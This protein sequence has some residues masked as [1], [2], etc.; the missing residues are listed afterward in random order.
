MPDQELTE[1][2]PEIA[3][4]IASEK[5]RQ[6]S[7]LELIAS[8]NF[9]SKAVMQAMGS[10]L[11]NKY[12]EGYPGKRYYGGNE[13]IDQMEILCQ[14]RTLAAFG[15]SG[16]EWGVNVQPLSGSPANFAVYT[17]LMQPGDKIM[18]LSLAHGGHLTHGHQTE[19]KKI[20]ASSI[21][22]ESQPYYVR[23]EDGLIDYEALAKQAA[24]F[25]PKMI[26]VG[27]SA[28]P[29]DYDYAKFREI[30]N[31][32]GAFLM[33]DIAHTSGLIASKLLNQPFEYC[34]VVTTTTHK[35]LRGPRSGL[36]MA[37]KQYIDAINFAVF[38]SLQ[39]GPHNVSIAA[40]AVQLK[41]VA[42]PEFK[43]YSQ[44]VI[45]NAQALAAGLMEQ[46]QTLICSGTVNHIV[47][48]DLRPHGL[49]GS[50]VE[51][52]LDLMHITTNKNSVVGDK[53]AVTPG[54][55]RL[56]TPALTTRG[57]LE[58]DMKIIA[59]FLVQALEISKA[60]QEKSGKKLVDFVKGLEENDD[61][62]RVGEEVK[63][64]ATQFSIPG[65]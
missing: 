16:E 30:A 31:S 60:V 36:I 39:G 35:S 40:L 58:D 52:V 27:A 15:I 44:Q 14:E 18:G 32:C 38:P 25:Q 20:S 57:M 50:K 10:C 26:V 49:T 65:V 4:I 34:D 41:E 54:G 13:F 47:M 24:E 6:Y 53:S 55:I 7:C 64:F 2:D 56:G 62:K 59:K 42:T 43:A 23:E 45:K 17:A 46:G 51:K 9:T 3:A 29:A 28:Y 1:K 11:C 33:A 12:S 5:N 61:L 48:W 37:K 21:Y 63:A 22:F 19:T 8:E